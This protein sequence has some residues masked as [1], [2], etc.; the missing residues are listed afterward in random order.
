M[1]AKPR[2]SIAHVEGSGTAETAYAPW[3]T[4]RSLKRR[5]IVQLS[6]PPETSHLKLGQGSGHP[7]EH[8]ADPLLLTPDNAA[9]LANI[10]GRDLEREAMRNDGVVYVKPSSNH[11]QISDHAIDSGAI[12]L[13]R[14]GLENPLS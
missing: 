5:I 3:R 13:N 6:A 4:S 8:Q 14:S 7:F 11:G 1:P 10:A 9:T 12:E 2:I